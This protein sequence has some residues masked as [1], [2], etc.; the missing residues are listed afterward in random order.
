MYKAKD[1]RDQSLEELEAIYQ[2]SCKKLFELNNQFRS[3]K[4][5]EKP[6]EIKHARKDIARLLTVMTEKRRQNQTHSS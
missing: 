1:L 4:K 6:H 3:Q 2:E 5:R